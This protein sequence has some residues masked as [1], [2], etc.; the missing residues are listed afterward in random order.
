[1][2]KEKL[3]ASALALNTFLTALTIKTNAKTLDVP[4]IYEEEKYGS[5]NTNIYY[6]YNF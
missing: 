1:M 4:Y 3:V 5:I 2:K 6:D